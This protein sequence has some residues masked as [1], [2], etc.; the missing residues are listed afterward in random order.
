MGCLDCGRGITLGNHQKTCLV[1]IKGGEKM[2]TVSSRMASDVQYI[3]L[4]CSIATPLPEAAIVL[5]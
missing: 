2:I 4:L 1:K 5:Y 3:C